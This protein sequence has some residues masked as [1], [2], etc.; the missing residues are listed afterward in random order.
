VLKL[1][2]LQQAWTDQRTRDGMETHYGLG[3]GVS[4]RSGRKMVGFNGL[5]P[6]STTAFR[7]FPSDGVGV[8]ALCNAEVLAGNGH[9]D[10]SSVVDP[11]LD[12]IFR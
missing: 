7:Y 4:E 8:V 10:L 11:V 5:N 12:A 1:E 3:W 9:Q 2:L 6:S